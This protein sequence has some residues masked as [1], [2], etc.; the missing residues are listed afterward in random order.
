MTGKHATE[1]HRRI[2]DDGLI[3]RCLVGSGVHGISVAA[4]DA[5]WACAS[6]RL[7]T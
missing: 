1:E 7:S 2:A 6:S 5:R 3:F 4:Q